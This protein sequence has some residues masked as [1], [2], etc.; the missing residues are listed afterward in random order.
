[1]EYREWINACSRLIAEKELTIAF[2][3]SASA[4]KLAF[5]FSQ[6]EFSGRIL[7]GGI[8]CYNV[9]I[10]EAVLGIPEA[11]IAE[12][13]PESPEVTRE[14]AERLRKMMGAGITVAITGL[15]TPGGSEHPGKPVGTMFYCVLLGKQVL[16]RKKIFSGTPAQIIDL[17]IEQV[18]KTLVKALES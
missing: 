3:E 8:V 2:A 9:C 18:A 17:T 6:T 4:G 1:M 15:T 13:T 5:E 14:M 7:K 12:Y 10:K 11:M 16:E